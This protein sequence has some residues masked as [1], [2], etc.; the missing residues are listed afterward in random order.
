MFQFIPPSIEYWNEA[1]SYFFSVSQKILNLIEGALKP[2]KSK[3]GLVSVE[4]WLLEYELC[5]SVP[6]IQHFVPLAALLITGLMGVPHDQSDA[7][8]P[9]VQLPLELSKFSE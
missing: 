1:P 4:F 7:V 5:V 2:D 6:V 3:H 8:P 9:G